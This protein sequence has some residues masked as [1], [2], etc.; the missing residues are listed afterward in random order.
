MY[1]NKF[2][3][4]YAR[5]ITT[6]AEG[7]EHDFIYIGDKYGIGKGHEYKIFRNSIFD[8]IRFLLMLKSYDKVIFHTLPTSYFILIL[9]F[10]FK[11]SKLERLYLVLWGGEI[12]FKQDIPFKSK[13]MSY[14]S[15]LFL[16]SM[17]GF[18]TY[19]DDDYNLAKKISNNSIVKYINVGSFYPSNIVIGTDLRIMR[20]ERSIETLNVMI[21]ASALKRNAHE[22]IIDRLSNL[23]HN[24]KSVKY[25]IPLSYGD[26]D[27]ASFV[28][29]YAIDKL[30]ESNVE[31]IKRFIE[32]EEYKNFLS[33]IDIAIFGHTGQQAMG[34][35]LNLLSLGTNIYLNRQSTSSE[36]LEGLGFEIFDYENI[37]FGT[38]QLKNNVTLANLLFS[39]D[40]TIKKQNVFYSTTS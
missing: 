38:H 11:F 2:V 31:V 32:P 34:N 8:V 37:S 39:F 35:I 16:K 28:E 3:P 20:S 23:N 25:Y 24:H 40:A 21:G 18:I 14:F 27:Y 19:I 29:A 13:V 10:L 17:N 6:F 5:M 7:S 22:L 30:G 12:H 26:L 36:Y 33:K 4:D 9:P 1:R 15:T